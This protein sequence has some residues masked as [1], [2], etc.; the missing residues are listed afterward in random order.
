M[1]LKPRFTNDF[2][3]GRNM[4]KILLCATLTT[5]IVSLFLF[6]NNVQA[7]NIMVGFT[8]VLF[9]ALVYTMWRYC[10]CPRC[11]RHIVGG[12][13]VVKVCPHCKRHLS[14]GQKMKK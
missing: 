1:D 2:E 8:V 5:A 3:F 14:S 9:A 12:V 7:Q 6:Q 4:A 13:L 10:K 11:G